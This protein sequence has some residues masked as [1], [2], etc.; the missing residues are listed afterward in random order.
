MKNNSV[1]LYET[2]DYLN[3]L[4]DFEDAIYNS[5]FHYS[6]RNLTF[7]ENSLPENCLEALQKSLRIC[8]LAGIESRHHFKK[9]YVYDLESQTIV[10]DWR[11]SQEGFNLIIMQFSSHNENT[12][13]WLWKLAGL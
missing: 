6:L 2:N 3:H 9:V 8:Q 1:V 5:K 11:M 12:A 13:H 7:A 10:I 4:R